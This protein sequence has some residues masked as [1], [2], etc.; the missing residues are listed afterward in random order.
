ML[1]KIRKKTL[2]N[3]FYVGLSL[4]VVLFALIGVSITTNYAVG[5]NNSNATVIAIVNVLKNVI[6][7][8]ISCPPNMDMINNFS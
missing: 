6:L 4:A 8:F 1:I 3:V 2:E 7:T 5:A